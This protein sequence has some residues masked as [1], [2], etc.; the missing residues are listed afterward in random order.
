MRRLLRLRRF[1]LVYPLR[2]IAVWVGVRFAAAFVGITTP[3]GLQV[4]LIL[5]AVGLA[6]R[7][8]ARRRNEDLFLANLG[9]AVWAIPALAIGPPLLIELFLVSRR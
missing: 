5:G 6:V 7:L 3:N 2:G 9:I 1:R 8:D 4:L